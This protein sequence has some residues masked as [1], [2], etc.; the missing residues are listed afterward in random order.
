MNDFVMSAQAAVKNA[1]AK[2]LN[3][4]AAHAA[5]A[6]RWALFGMLAL[7]GTAAQAAITASTTF[8]PGSWNGTGATPSPLSVPV[9]QGDE[10]WLLIAVDNSASN[11]VTAL[12]GINNLPGGLVLAP[13][14]SAFASPSCSAGGTFNATPG[15]ATFGFSGFQIPAK[16]AGING[17]CTVYARVKVFGTLT[18]TAGDVSTMLNTIDPSTGPGTGIRGDDNG[19]TV[20]NALKAEQSI[21]AIKLADPSVSKGFS[22]GTVPMGGTS[23]VTI[24]ITNNAAADVDL[25]TLSENLPATLTATTTP[26]VQCAGTG[27]PAALTN[28][29]GSFPSLTFPANTKLAASGTCTISF[30]VRAQAQSGNGYTANNSIPANGLGNSRLLNSP[31]AGAN[32]NVE[33]PLLTSKSF[34]PSTAAANQLVTMTINLQNRSGFAISAGSLS[35]TFAGAVSGGGVMTV[36][37]PGGASGGGAGCAAASAF[38][39]PTSAGFISASGLTIPANSSCSYTV[40]VTVDK[41][42]VY[43]NITSATT[44]SSAD[45]NV[46]TQTNSPAAATLTAYD[47]ITAS[48]AAQDPRNPN[49]GANVVAPGNRIVYRV[50]VSNYTSSAIGDVQVTDPLP[51]EV[52]S[53]AQVVYLATSGSTPTSVTGAGCSGP[54]SVTGT[55]AVPVFNGISVPAGTGANPGTCV[56]EFWVQIPT[57]WPVGIN[58]ANSIPSNNITYSSG[59][60]SLQ[61]STVVATSPTVNRLTIGKSVLP[62]TVFQGDTAVVTVTLNNNSYNAMTAA[63]F[64][65]AALFGASNSV[66]NASP[67]N[68]STTCTGSPVYTYTAGGSSFAAS[69]L[70]VPARGNCV[71]TWRVVGIN[72]GGPY[73][74]TLPAA[75]VSGTVDSGAG[76]VT[77]NAVGN[78]TVDMTVNSVLN[79]TKN[80]SPSTVG[81]AG[82]VSRVT[83]TLQNVGNAALTRVSALDNLLPSG[84]TVNNPANASTTCGGTSVVNPLPGATAVNLTGGTLYANST[85]LVQFDVISSTNTPSVNSINPGD[86]TADNGVFNASAASATLNKFT[87]GTVNITKNFNPQTLAAVGGVS[88]LTVSVQ[89]NVGVPVN[90]TNAGFIDNMPPGM[91][92]SPTPSPVSDCVGAVITATPGASSFSM[93][94]ATLP[95][96]GS[97]LV[98]V[99]VTLVQSDAS[100]NVLPAGVVTN[101]QKITNPSPFSSTLTTLATLGIEKSFNPPAA[102]PNTPVQLKIRVL[103]SLALSFTNLSVTDNLPAGVTVSSPSALSTTCTGATVNASGGSVTMTGGSLA[104]AVGNVATSCEITLLVQAA[105]VGPYINS[106]PAGGLTGLGSNGSPAANIDPPAR[107]VL[108]GLQPLSLTKA[109]ANANRIP[110]Q[111]NTLTI[112]ITNP[113][114]SAINSVALTD[115][116]PV[117]AYLV[118][119]PNQS[120]TCASSTITENGSPLTVPVT[121]SATGGGSSL[122][123]SGA[124]IP[125]NG[126]CTFQADVLSNQIG[127]FVNRIP[128]GAI[129][130]F[131]GVTNPV[132]AVAQFTTFDPPVLG[133]QFIPVQISSGGTAKLRIVLGNT[134]S[135][136]LTLTS[137]LVDNLPTAPGA[138]TLAAT[139]IDTAATTCTLGS[140]NASAGGNAVT[141]NSGALIPSGGCVIVVNVTATAEGTY[142]NV[143]PG[144]GLAT[145]GGSNPVPATAAI[146]VSNTLAS[147]SGRVYRDNN[148]DGIPNGAEAGI[149]AQVIELLDSTGT[150]VVATT[151]TDSLGN[152]AF[153][154]LTPG[155]YRVREPAQPAGTLNGITSVGTI[156][157]TPSGTATAVGTTPSLISAITVAGGQSSIDNNF[158]ELVPSRLAGKVFLDP[159]NNG[160]Q[161]GGEPG[162][163]G[164]VMTL[165]GSNDLGPLPAGITATTGADGSYSFTGLRPGSYTITEGAQPSGT[166]NG[167]TTASAVNAIGSST[168]APGG[169]SGTAT[170]PTVL[171]VAAPVGTSRIGANGGASVPITLPSNAE[172]LNND[173]AEIPTSRSV[174]GRIFTDVNN[175]GLFNST[176]SAIGGQLLTLT[177]L[178]AS[179]SPVSRTVN[180]NADGTYS[181][182]NLPESNGAG[183]TVSYAT[184]GSPAGNTL[185]LSVVGSTGGTGAAT[186]ANRI[187]LS[188]I[189]LTGLLA[190]SGNN[191][192]TQRPPGVI[193][194]RVYLDA[195]NNGLF[196]PTPGGNDAPL[197]G[198]QM[199][200]TG[201]DYGLDGVLGGGDDIV[202]PAVGAVGAITTNTAPDGTYS[203]TN[204]R[205]GNYSVVEPTQP[206]NSANGI[207]TA[208][209]VTSIPAGGTP[210]VAT[211]LT[212]APSAVNNIALPAGGTSPNNNFGEIPTGSAITGFVWKDTNN[213]GLLNTGELGIVGV[214]IELTGLDLAGQNVTRFVDTLADGSYAFNSLP[215]GTFTVTEPTQPVGTLNG[216]T[217]KGSTTGTA[218]PVATLPSAIAAITVGVNQISINNNFGE[219]PVASISG[220]VY[221]DN[222]NNGSIDTGE[223]GIPNVAVFLD[224]V[225]DLGTVIHVELNTLTDGTY[226]FPSL[227]PGTY[228]VTEPT[229]PANT[230]NGITSAGTVNG[231]ALGT[232]TPVNDPVSVVSAI[233]LGAGAQSINNNFGEIGDSPDMLVSKSHSP[234]KFT[235]NNPGTYTFTV[236]NAGQ[237]N[238]TGTYT[239]SDR[240]P[241]GLTLAATPSGTGW[242]C[243]GAAGASSFSCTSSTVVNAGA[244]SAQS[245]EAKIAVSAAAAAASPAQN[246]VMVDGGGEY[247]AR[248]PTVAERDAFNNNPLALPVCDP[249]VLHNVCRDPTPVQLAASLSGT[250]WYDIGTTLKVLDGGDRRLPNWKVELVNPATGQVVATTTTGADGSYKLVDLIPGI[251]WAVRFRDPSSNVVFGYP[252]NGE[253]APGSSGASCDATAALANG[254]ASSCVQ[255]SPSTE[256][257]I[258]LAP[259]QNLAQQSL[260]VDPSG[261]VYDSTTRQPVPGSVVTLAPTG[262]C[263]GY[264]P[265]TSLVNIAAGGYTVAGTSTSMTVGADGFYQFLF[266]PAAPPSC[267]F[268]LSVTPPAGYT[269]VSTVIPAETTTLTA[270]GG[271][272]STFAVQ[273]QAS[274][275]NG[276]PG[277]AT[278]YYLAV[279]SGSAGANIIHN[280]IPI[281]PAVPTAL[282]LTKTG[283]KAQAEVGDSVL[284]TVTVRQV[285]GPALGQVTVHDRLP[286]GFTLIRGTVRVNGVSVA[287]PVGGL[288]PNLGFNLGAIAKNAQIA[289]TYRVRVGVGSQQGDGTNRAKAFGCGAPGGCLTPTFTPIAGAVPSNEGQHRVKVTGGVFTAQ[290]CVV[291]KI[292]VD[293]NNNHVQ[294]PE[295]LGIPGVRLYMEDGSYVVS[296]SEGKYSQCDVSPKSHVLKV[297]PLTLPRGSRLTTSSNRNLG[298]AGSL[299]IDL[300][301]GELHRA[302]FVEGSCSNTVLEQVKMRRSQGEV[303]SVETEK[304]KGPALKFESKSRGAP[305]EATDSAN[306]PIVKPRTPSPGGGIEIPKSESE[307]NIP[308]WQLP[309]N[310]P[311][312]AVQGGRNAR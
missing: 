2:L 204:L 93:S 7:V 132:A 55:A 138:M 269:F 212:T 124:Q 49:D 240:L 293:C 297:D 239:V 165:S 169:V 63:Q 253:Q 45:S 117:N 238:S 11:N 190:S 291:G 203:F 235:V 126:S 156:A 118:N 241:P 41:D 304:K 227:R 89:N 192:F 201:T 38:N 261:V 92:L 160:T 208:G 187:V 54:S 34:T 144:G 53:G 110:G 247:E 1:A 245:F 30:T 99:N 137:N 174:S 150:T 278:T 77:F 104:A 229:Q 153:L 178:D 249:A 163:A 96:S 116:L 65:D 232:A 267:A 217:V 47:Q 307:R 209:T 301:N 60:K 255:R 16:L 129:T 274:A 35:D 200:L 244:I 309:L 91:V 256:L 219:V 75:N 295:E 67:T 114:A 311:S 48:K 22:P 180:A 106:I 285:S 17:Q 257:G 176:D 173:F 10:A 61:G 265:A 149:D 52:G 262:V 140:I 86:V 13:T 206:A 120:T 306:Q 62:N 254:T 97:C 264:D 211:G 215:P 252:V 243:T 64:N 103:N 42:G 287:D 111:A 15:G 302:D 199:V 24:T 3:S 125:A 205:A 155:T 162:I 78:A 166:A 83:I 145:N 179:G 268:T 135:S 130:S 115:V 70:T 9:K 108:R 221:N 29:G 294:D 148:N 258:V 288:G 82:G 105:G 59:S 80:F 94:G 100:V 279:N 222:N 234:A 36:R 157:G 27:T 276:V 177:G 230:V 87:S 216:T 197:N 194:G 305:Q 271:V 231:V 310:A 136:A 308:V 299:F 8:L 237:R 84:L 57:N 188:G 20:F 46:G 218:T 263:T 139:P 228:R 31:A 131:E 58:I 33:S 23:Q 121:V 202:L 214:R 68:P 193:S 122:R 168:A 72:P 44:Y 272:G 225:N 185:G 270:P 248:R 161:Q 151:T 242:T 109:F 170:A 51:L 246:V 171:T 76:P 260:P 66:R 90:L 223:T 81:G 300:K 141:Y 143:I 50:T 251:P 43:N 85:C 181:F 280:H 113:N 128:D 250:V 28:M 284:Y 213:D 183:Y 101:D 21:Q 56:L 210:G 73:T 158:G 40:P 186:G 5:T 164:V 14:P 281:D 79:V 127:T 266:A 95:A 159:N 102:L 12:T 69:G 184:A 25:T 290:A 292:F 134:N 195:N 220:R 119:P 146:L 26:Q 312:S 282:A 18:G 236:R 32:L 283:D 191:N 19:T 39:A 123:I 71:V 172:S 147:I 259:G 6:K 189:P 167:I 74:N 152:Y 207:T 303:R 196:E 4:P 154:G 142:N 98:A 286:A 273:P 88:R 226:N 112:T 277:P 296:D 37:T 289:L 224:G 107:A 198:V 233:V 275:P 175:D 133:K 298:D 182:A